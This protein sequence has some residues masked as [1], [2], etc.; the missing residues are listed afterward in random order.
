MEGLDFQRLTGSALC[1]PTPHGPG[2]SGKLRQTAE[3]FHFPLSLQGEESKWSSGV[4]QTLITRD[5]VPYLGTC[6]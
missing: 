6:E 1:Y 4:E 5:L 2:A 3:C